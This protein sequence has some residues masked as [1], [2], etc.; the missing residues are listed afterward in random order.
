M[1]ALVA[2]AT[3][4]KMALT[5]ATNFA[6]GGIVYGETFARVGEYPGASS[7]P[8]VIAP[9]NKLKG[10]ISEGGSGGRVEFVIKGDTLQGVLNNNN[11]KRSRG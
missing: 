3:S 6:D 8:E 7:N 4:A 1:A 10:L 11:R 2:T 9:L 5:K